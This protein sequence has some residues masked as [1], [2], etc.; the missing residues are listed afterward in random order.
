MSRRKRSSRRTRRCR[1]FSSIPK[2]STWLYRIAVNKC[3]TR[4]GPAVRDTSLS[5][6]PGDEVAAWE[7]ADE[8]TPHR[9]LEQ[10][11]LAWELEQGIQALPQLYRESFVL[12]HVEGLAT[13][14]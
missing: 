10:V 3:T 11:E 4:C 12:K 2:F 1:D 13:T 8:E 14:R 5:T 7:A 6:R 9:E